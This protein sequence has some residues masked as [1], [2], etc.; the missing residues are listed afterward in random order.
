MKSCGKML[1]R[2]ERRRRDHQ[3]KHQHLRKDSLIE[4]P[5]IVDGLAANW[6]NRLTIRLNYS[7]RA[8]RRLFFVSFEEDEAARLAQF[9]HAYNSENSKRIRSSFSS[10]KRGE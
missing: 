5:S 3:A 2:R 4:D 10:K 1:R 7:V 9:L 8:N 6:L